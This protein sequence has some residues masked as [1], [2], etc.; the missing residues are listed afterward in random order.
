MSHHSIPTMTAAWT[1]R[2]SAGD[3]RTV[4]HTGPRDGRG[5]YEHALQEALAELDGFDVGAP[6]HAPPRGHAAGGYDDSDALDAAALFA[7]VPPS[8]P[9]P[10]LVDDALFHESP[11]L[12]LR[13]PSSLAP[14]M[15]AIHRAH[16]PTVRVQRRQSSS[17]LRAGMAAIAICGVLALIATLAACLFYLGT[18]HRSHGTSTTSAEAHSARRMGGVEQLDDG[19]NGVV[20]L[21]ARD[22]GAGAELGQ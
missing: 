20:A 1:T 16:A 17:T 2:E 21:T 10:A 22:D 18:P 19:A 5:V 13:A 8:E 9:P 3:D 15:N 6:Y 14:E 7:D 11:Y 12:A 4:A